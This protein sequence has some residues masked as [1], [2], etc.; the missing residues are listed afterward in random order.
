MRFL[1][2]QLCREHVLTHFKHSIPGDDDQSTNHPQTSGFD[3]GMDSYVREEEEHLVKDLH[4]Q[5]V[6][7]ETQKEHEQHSHTVLV[8]SF[9]S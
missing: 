8:F 1:T 7:A 9:T 5:L 2:R 4:E 3:E 6:E